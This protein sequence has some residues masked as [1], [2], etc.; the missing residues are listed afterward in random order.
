MRAIQKDQPVMGAL[1]KAKTCL[2][3]NIRE[4]TQSST[5]QNGKI[6]D[7]IEFERPRYK[8]PAAK[9]RRRIGQATWPE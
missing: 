9:K 6:N 2:R 5:T 4:K 1:W 3:K 7:W 8:G